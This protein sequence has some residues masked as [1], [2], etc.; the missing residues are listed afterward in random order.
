M[1]HTAQ[2]RLWRLSQFLRS[3]SKR[4]PSVLSRKHTKGRISEAYT[5]L[6]DIVR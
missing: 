2:N 6:D 5:L 3:N 1:V 4:I